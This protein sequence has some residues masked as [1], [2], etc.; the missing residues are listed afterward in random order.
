[1]DRSD[2]YRT[3]TNKINMATLRYSW[4][5]EST[6]SL[7]SRDHSTKSASSAAC[8]KLASALA[9]RLPCAHVFFLQIGTKAEPTS[10]LE[11]LTPAHYE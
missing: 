10:G 7:P 1:V 2:G 3:A 5:V 8:S 4:S 6:R 9:S 11:P